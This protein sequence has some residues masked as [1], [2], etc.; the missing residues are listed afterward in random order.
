MARRAGPVISPDPV[1]LVA[2]VDP[3]DR[4]AYPVDLADLP[5]PRAELADLVDRAAADPVAA[6]P[7]E[8]DLAAVGADSAD[9]VAAEAANDATA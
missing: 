9:P 2:P 7:V 3:A 5:G 4:A 6:D 8:V 1:I